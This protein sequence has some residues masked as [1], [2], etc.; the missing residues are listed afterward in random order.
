MDTTRLAA[1]TFAQS[2]FV[3]LRA[4]DGCSLPVPAELSYNTSD[5]YAL[6]IS[7]FLDETP[8]P[9]RFARDLLSDGLIEPSGDGDVHVWPGPDDEGA[10]VVTIELCSPHGDALVEVRT[11]DAVAFVE[12]S[13]ALVAPGA[14][15]AHLDIDATITAIRAAENA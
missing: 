9:W 2:L 4:E 5:P 7:F 6:T 1:Q 8:V 13:H 12:R 15:S 11:G 10:P 14:E 3:G